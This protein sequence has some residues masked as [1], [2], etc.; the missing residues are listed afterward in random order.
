[1]DLLLSPPSSASA[2]P[3]PS[4]T[5]SDPATLTDCSSLNGFCQDL[6][7]ET[8][9][10]VFVCVCLCSGWSSG[11]HL[12][13]RFGVVDSRRD[14][15]GSGTP[16]QDGPGTELDKPLCGFQYN[17]HLV[18]VRGTAVL[19]PPDVIQGSAVDGF[20]LENLTGFHMKKVVWL[21]FLF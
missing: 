12:H 6:L 8:R 20:N 17:C 14:R 11:S 19:G 2:S 3:L 9:C 13:R 10:V 1:M 5:R 21:T 18:A 16:H 15:D 4:S 7:C